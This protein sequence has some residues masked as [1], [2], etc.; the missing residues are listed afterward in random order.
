MATTVYERKISVGNNR[1]GQAEQL[2]VLMQFSYVKQQKILH[3]QSS[4]T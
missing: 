2:V 1:N 3:D 4:S